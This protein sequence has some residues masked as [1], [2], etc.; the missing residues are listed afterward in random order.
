MEWLRESLSKI[1]SGLHNLFEL[2]LNSTG[3]YI[4][5]DCPGQI[6]LYTHHS[7]M[8]NILESI[9]KNGTKVRSFLIVA[10]F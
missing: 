5:F 10:S 2:L 4:L 8:K 6:E 9:S 3:D 1:S 7:S